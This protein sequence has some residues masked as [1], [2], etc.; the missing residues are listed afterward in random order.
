M[1]TY[2]PNALMANALGTAI[3]DIMG[4]Q[5]QTEKWRG[6]FAS[7]QEDLLQKQL[8]SA[9]RSAFLP[10]EAREKALTL[11]GKEIEQARGETGLARER[12]EL[13]QQP[14]RFGRERAEEGRKA[15][16]EGRRADL[17][18][19]GLRKAEVEVESLESAA[20]EQK[21]KQD[22]WAYWRAKPPENMADFNRMLTDLGQVPKSPLEAG[23]LAADTALALARARAVQTVEVKLSELQRKQIADAERHA[24]RVAADTMFKLGIKESD[25][26]ALDYFRNKA[27]REALVRRGFDQQTLD[28]I[29]HGQEPA[30]PGYLR[31]ILDPIE[32]G[33]NPINWLFGRGGKR[34]SERGAPAGTPGTPA[35][36]AQP[37]GGW[38][39]REK[40]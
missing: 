14:V 33:G 15:A 21:R 36:P 1:A 7:Q 26:V 10:Y 34:R 31:D 17:H 3:A 23:K 20:A 30:M 22:A 24:D 6:D 18:R 9:R 28:A 35:A 40:K 5:V 38:Q 16:E 19:P 27:I 25:P 39:I 11:T 32:Y 8:E 29:G 4:K 2:D 37:G 13:A 12:G